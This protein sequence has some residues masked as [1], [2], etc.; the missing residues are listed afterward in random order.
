MWTVDLPADLNSRD[1]DGFGWTLLAEAR[2]PSIVGSGAICLAGEPDTL[3]VV[4]VVDVGT[5][6]SAIVRFRILPGAIDDYVQ[7]IRRFRGE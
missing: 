7:A 4:E 5:G 2:D 6:D 1:S 3:A